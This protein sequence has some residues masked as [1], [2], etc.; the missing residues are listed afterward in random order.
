MIDVG[1]SEN[2]VEVTEIGSGIA[3]IDVVEL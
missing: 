2:D 3:E 1:V